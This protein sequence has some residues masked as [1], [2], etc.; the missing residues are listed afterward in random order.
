MHTFKC[1]DIGYAVMCLARYFQS[2]LKGHYLALKGVAKYLCATQTYGIYYWRNSPH[3]DLPTGPTPSTSSEKDLPPFLTLNGNLTCFVDA[4]HTTDLNTRRSVTGY[5][6]CYAGGVVAYKSKLQ[7][8]CNTSS[9]EAKFIAAVT[10]G[11]MVK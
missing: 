5:G 10:A 1:C 8:T 7:A 3:T 2:P 9:A 6:V 4:A 11:K